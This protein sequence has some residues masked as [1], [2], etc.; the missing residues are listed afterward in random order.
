MPSPENNME[1]ANEGT[2]HHRQNLKEEVSATHS[3]PS[4]AQESGSRAASQ[5]TAARL[6]RQTRTSPRKNCTKYSEGQE[7]SDES[8]SEDSELEEE[9]ESDSDE[10]VYCRCGAPNSDD[11]IGCDGKNCKYE[12]FHF[13]C[14]GI[15]PKKVPRGKWFCDSCR[16]VKNGVDENWKAKLKQVCQEIM[17]KKITVPSASLAY[18]FSIEAISEQLNSKPILTS[19]EEKRLVEM[20]VNMCKQGHWMMVKDSVVHSVKV[21]LDVEEKMGI[22]RLNPFTNNLPENDWWEAFCK[23]HPKMEEL[24]KQHESAVDKPSLEQGKTKEGLSVQETISKL[25]RSTPQESTKRLKNTAQEVNLKHK[26]YK[27]KK[28]LVSDPGLKKPQAAHGGMSRGPEPTPL[29][30]LEAIIV[31]K[32]R[33]LFEKRFKN[34]DKSDSDVVY[35]AWR[36]LKCLCDD[37]EK[38]QDDPNKLCVPPT[39]GDIPPWSPCP[40]GPFYISDESSRTSVSLLLGNLG[41]KRK[42]RALLR[43]ESMKAK[44]G[45]HYL[46]PWRFRLGSKRQVLKSWKLEVK[47]R[48]RRKSYITQRFEGYQ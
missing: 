9:S 24:R 5:G 6:P 20:A 11:M 41:K 30:C 26:K 16:I 18:G 14:V 28:N 32:Q 13:K 42:K 8:G 15:N 48:N 36:A 7:T 25:C 43:I 17:A 4:T 29:E 22:K 40:N 2:P 45:R 19:Q 12:W 23:R 39:K 35:S 46:E 21:L 27:L 3:P 34:G 33:H 1:D 10:R 31:K 37:S 47:K 44:Q 38:E